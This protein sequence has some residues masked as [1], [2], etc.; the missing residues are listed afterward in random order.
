LSDVVCLGILVADVLGRP[1]D[2]WPERGRLSLVEEMTLHIGGCAANTGIGLARLGADVA[3]VGKVGRDGFGDFVIHTLRANG[4]NVDGVLRDDQ[5]NTSATMVMVA[6]DGERSF[7]HHIGANATLK[8]EEVRQ[9]VVART[10]ILHY[11]GAL[12]MPGFDG[13]PAASVLERAKR[14]GVTTCLDTVWDATGRWMELVGPCLPHVDILLPSLDEAIMLVGKEEPADVAQALHDRGVGT[15]ALKMGEKGCYVSS[16]SGQA[17]QQPTFEADVVDATG[18]GDAFAAG[19]IR[20]VL[21]GWDLEQTAR[22]AC[23]VGAL[24][25]TALGTTAGVR[26]FQETLEFLKQ[27]RPEVDRCVH[28]SAVGCWLACVWRPGR[29]RTGR[30]RF[31]VCGKMT[32]ST[33]RCAMC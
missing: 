15:V 30:A 27:A 12:V 19:F 20:G 25:V 24:C 32:P 10:K 16:A 14:A 22:F 11:A 31:P 3:V 9:E 7:L 18:A 21:E 29:Q 8:P 5:A 4:L 26:S 28:S 6:S 13:P 1:V 23:A 17:F 33:C 2:E